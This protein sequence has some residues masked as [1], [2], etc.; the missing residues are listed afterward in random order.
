[1]ELRALRDT[2]IVVDDNSVVAEGW[3]V[4]GARRSRAVPRRVYGSD[5]RTTSPFLGDC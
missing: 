3:T 4:L 1:M 5:V 2:S